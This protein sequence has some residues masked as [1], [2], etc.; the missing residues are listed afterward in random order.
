MSTLLLGLRSLFHPV[1]PP[2]DLDRAK[3]WYSQVL[4]REPY[5]DE[6]FYVGFDVGGYELGLLPS[7][8]P[9]DRPTCAWGVP[10]VDVTV[11][12]LVEAG[13]TVHEEVREVG[14]GIRTAA[15]TDPL[16]T[17]LSL[18]E[19]PHFEVQPPES[20]GPGR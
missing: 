15:V 16:G 19:N 7:D 10:D 13:A 2:S 11:A 18:I 4:G 17:V 20:P 12:E 3:A 6:P 8:D 9:D 14:G 5:F 1:C